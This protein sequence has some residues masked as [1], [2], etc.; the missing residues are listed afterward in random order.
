[1][2]T[3]TLTTDTRLSRRPGLLPVGDGLFA[4]TAPDALTLTADRR[5]MA[6]R[7]VI[8]T[9]T[10]DR[11]GD[12]VVPAGLRNPAEYLKNPVVLWAH[13]RATMPPVGTCV[14]LEVEADRVIATTRFARG[15]AFSE[16]LFRLYEQGVLRAWSIGFVPVHAR[17][18]PRDADG[19]RGLRVETW[20]L[21]E[22]SAVP[23]PEN[24]EALTLA[25]RKGLV[26]DPRLRG[27][28]IAAAG[29]VMDDLVA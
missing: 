15:S 19:R 29:D 4:R 7:A 12:V 28:L 17:V 18:R 1:M 10:P 23:V 25:V 22:Y 26:R 11:A 21:L 24:P 3:A 20:D 13:Q 27:W 2:M 8:S 5:E 14:S 6:V 16:E 9:A